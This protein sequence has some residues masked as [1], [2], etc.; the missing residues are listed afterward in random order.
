MYSTSLTVSCFLALYTIAASS[1]YEETFTALH[2]RAAPY[3]LDHGLNSYLFAREAIP[4]EDTDEGSW[5]HAADVLKRHA[6]PQP[7]LN[8]GFELGDTGLYA[9]TPGKGH[10]QGRG[11]KGG[12]GSPKNEN[13]KPPQSAAQGELASASKPPKPAVKGSTPGT[14]PTKKELIDM[15]KQNYNWPPPGYKHMSKNEKK[16]AGAKVLQEHRRKLDK[17]ASTPEKPGSG[18][19]VKDM[20]SKFEKASS[21]KPASSLFPTDKAIPNSEAPPIP[22][23]KFA[24]DPRSSASSWAGLS[25]QSSLSRPSTPGPEGLSRQDSDRSGVHIEKPL[26]LSRE[27]SNDGW[28]VL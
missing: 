3:T 27:P 2:S 15:V 7:Q 21:G 20:I 11:G 4:L 1:M 19:S 24:H 6:G 14:V 18:E 16:A 25:R 13:N 26:A 28:T 10:K 12:G 17:L 8:A 23:S 9:R 5:F 22:T